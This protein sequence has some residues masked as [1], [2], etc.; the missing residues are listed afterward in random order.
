[1]PRQFLIQVPVKPSN[2]SDPVLLVQVMILFDRSLRPRQEN[3]RHDLT[4]PKPT[5][6]TGDSPGSW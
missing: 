2:D 5:I 4:I 6:Q 1:M 3:N